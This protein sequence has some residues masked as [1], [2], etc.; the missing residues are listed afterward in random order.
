MN[1]E[2]A[3]NRV[4]SLVGTFVGLLATASLGMVL[5][6]AQP[7]MASFSPDYLNVT[8]TEGTVITNGSSQS[9]PIT[10][11]YDFSIGGASGVDYS[12]QAISV[13]DI[14]ASGKGQPCPGFDLSTWQAAGWKQIANGHLNADGTFH[15]TDTD[16]SAPQYGTA[17]V[18]VMTGY[19]FWD[20]SVPWSATLQPAP[21]PQ[22]STLPPPSTPTTCAGLPATI[23]GT[24]GNDNLIGTAKRDIVSL[25]AGNDTFAGKGGND[26]VC[27]GDGN[28][29]LTGGAGKDKLNGENGNDALKGGTDRDRC[30]GGDGTDTAA[31]SCER[32]LNIP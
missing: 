28:D 3:S 11:T 26:L 5:G 16:P 20:N 32:K 22:P 24:S 25:G 6:P 21:E 13:Y 2:F 30:D 9:W 27:G 29:L 8:A 1:T 7:A 17:C 4:K 15:G 10:I 18:H 23:V 14:F 31:R 19:N 12:S